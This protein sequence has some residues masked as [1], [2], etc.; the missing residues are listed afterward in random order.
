MRELGGG[1]VDDE[2]FESQ[3]EALDGVEARVSLTISEQMKLWRLLVPDRDLQI[4]KAGPG[5]K[6]WLAGNQA[7]G[8][9]AWPNVVVVE[10]QE[11]ATMILHYWSFGELWVL[12]SPI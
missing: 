8:D 1:K 6:C 7:R 10:G 9:R 3:A 4:P 11:R 12:L 5:I 2:G